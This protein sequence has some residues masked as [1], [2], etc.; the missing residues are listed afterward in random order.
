MTGR[1]A[2]LFA[3][4][5]IED[6]Q[7][8]YRFKL[9]ES[10]PK[11]VR[12]IGLEQIERVETQLR[13][14]QDVATAVH[15][16]RRCLKR[17]RA[18]LLLLRPAL[19][20]DV[21]RREAKRLAQ[22]GR[23][24]SGA[25]DRFV[26]L[27]TLQ[28][29]ET[30]NGALPGDCGPMLAALITDGHDLTAPPEIGLRQEALAKLGASRKF[31]SSRALQHIAMTD[32]WEGLETSHR[33]GRQAFRHCYRKPHDE[34]VHSW[35]KTVQRHWR[36]M[37][38]LSR[39]WPDAMAARISEAKALSQ[40]LGEDHDLAVLAALASQ[41]RERLPEDGVASLIRHAKSR[42]A[43]LRALARVHGERLYSERPDDL[44]SR[45]AGYWDAASSMQRHAVAVKTTHAP[46]A[47][48]PTPE[49]A[50]LQPMEEPLP[51][52]A[53]EADQPAVARLSQGRAKKRASA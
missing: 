27:Q 14:E 44:A 31:F 49:H 39:A 50:D 16:A 42:Q 29:I 21:Y 47:A 38:L 35:R 43:D 51:P 20:N 1:R 23:M 48:R 5:I 52:A 32:V 9:R 2:L 34:A 46:E 24:L 33:K 17:L 13:A 53:V 41:H 26:M 7:M 25:R 22:V 28:A 30:A 36:H 4:P 6:W 19:D 18:L 10:L 3:N 40:I 12:R 15:D 45:I 11:G 37:G 8:A